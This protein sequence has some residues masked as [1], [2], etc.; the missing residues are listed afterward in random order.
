M[1]RTA[2]RCQSADG[3]T[4]RYSVPMAGCRKQPK[5]HPQ[6][7]GRLLRYLA[8]AKHMEGDSPRQSN[9]DHPAE[10]QAH[11]PL[12]ERWREHWLTTS[13]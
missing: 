9:V 6:C 2:S 4:V 8:V 11:Q 7:D 1:T 12:D 5:Q 13:T 10:R 3:K